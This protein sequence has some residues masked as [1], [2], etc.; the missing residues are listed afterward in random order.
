[1]KSFILKNIQILASGGKNGKAEVEGATFSLLRL[2]RKV[3]LWATPC[4]EHRVT[5]TPGTRLSLQ[6]T[7]SILSF[8]LRIN[9]YNA[10]YAQAPFGGFKMSGNGREL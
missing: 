3:V 8:S 7:A 6:V 1:M 9:C 5:G 4:V 2:W 10:I